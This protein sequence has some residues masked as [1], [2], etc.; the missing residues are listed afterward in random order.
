MTESSGITAGD[1]EIARIGRG[2][3]RKSHSIRFSDAEWNTIQAQAEE[4]DMMPG[5]YVRHDRIR[6]FAGD[7]SSRVPGKV[8][9]NRDQGALRRNA[10][11]VAQYQ[12]VG[13]VVLGQDTDHSPAGCRQSPAWSWFVTARIAA[14]DVRHLRFVEVL[15]DPLPPSEQVPCEIRLAFVRGSAETGFNPDQETE[16]SATERDGRHRR[17]DPEQ[18]YPHPRRAVVTG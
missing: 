16:R 2:A 3:A 18:A 8:V 4:N 7:R 5:E 11:V 13:S 9:T 6:S 17:Q 15:A 10:P 1:R 12:W 14:C